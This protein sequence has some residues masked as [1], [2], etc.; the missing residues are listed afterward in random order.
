MSHPSA[1]IILL[2]LV[3]RKLFFCSQQTMFC[4][5]RQ[6]AIECIYGCHLMNS[7]SEQFPPWG[8][9]K[10]S[11]NFSRFDFCPA[12]TE[13][14]QLIQQNILLEVFILKQICYFHA[15][16]PSPNGVFLRKPRK[17]SYTRLA[18]FTDLCDAYKI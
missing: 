17:Y 6:R 12:F 2:Q 8:L 4:L 18:M 9:H 1:V 14:N 16:S 5:D 3:A 11:E 10:D 13:N 7:T 15:M